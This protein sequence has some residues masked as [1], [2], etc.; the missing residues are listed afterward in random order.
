MVSFLYKVMPILLENSYRKLK[1]GLRFQGPYS[2]H[3]ID[4]IFHILHEE[5]YSYASLEYIPFQLVLP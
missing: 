2:I 4:T 5:N 1:M 3:M